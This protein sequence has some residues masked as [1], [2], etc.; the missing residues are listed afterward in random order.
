[1]ERETGLDAALLSFGLSA[2]GVSWGSGAVRS[3]KPR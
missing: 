1:L 3:L 2:A